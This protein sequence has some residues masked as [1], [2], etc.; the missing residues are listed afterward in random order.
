MPRTRAMVSSL[1]SEWWS[2]GEQMA[3]DRPERADHGIA[4]RQF[5]AQHVFDI[6]I[7]KLGHFPALSLMPA[8]AA[9]G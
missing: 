9:L 7:A 8:I 6:L 2:A 3:Q 4:L 5:E 1:N